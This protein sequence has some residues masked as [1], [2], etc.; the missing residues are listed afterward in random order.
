MRKLINLLFRECYDRGNNGIIGPGYYSWEHYRI[1]WGKIAIW[2]FAF[3]V[4][5]QLSLVLW[6]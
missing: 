2:L 4:L 5:I 3:I 6:G 1:S